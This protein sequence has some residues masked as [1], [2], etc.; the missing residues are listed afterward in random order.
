[1]KRIQSI[2]FT[3][4]LLV[5]AMACDDE[6]ESKGVAVGVIRYPAIEIQGDELTMIAA[7]G[8][9]EDAGARAFLGTDDI[10]GELET[11]SNLD[12]TTPGVYTVNYTVSTV[13]ELDQESTATAQRLIIVAPSNPN[14]AVDLSGTYARNTNAAPAVWTKVTD[15]VYLND[16]IGGVLPPSIAVLPVYVFHFDDNSITIPTQPVPNGYGL[17]SAEITLEPNGYSVVIDNVGFLTN[18][19]TFIKQ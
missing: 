16:N 8:T 19:R 2:F 11:S 18:T 6:P 13:N 4:A 9:Y 17:L 14:T 3:I 15:G 7:G 10:T 1:M 12:P 5:I